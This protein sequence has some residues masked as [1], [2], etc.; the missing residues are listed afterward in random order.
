MKPNA[1]APGIRRRGVLA[2]LG[3]AALFAAS[4]AHLPDT[5]VKQIQGRLRRAESSP[6]AFVE[7]VFVPPH[8]VKTVPEHVDEVGVV[9]VYARHPNRD[10]YSWRAVRI[11][12][13]S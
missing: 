6:H 4:P 3:L 9:A 12:A 7:D 5:D 11:S 10:G 1:K 8:V 13:A 2:G